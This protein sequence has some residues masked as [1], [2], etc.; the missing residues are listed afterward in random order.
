M[1]YLKSNALEARSL[2]SGNAHR[3]TAS[4]APSE[5]NEVNE[6]MPNRLGCELGAQMDDLQRV[7]G[8]ASVVERERETLRGEGSLRR[9]FEDD[10]IAGDECREHGVDHDE[11]RVAKMYEKERVR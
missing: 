8:D 6:A 5:C 2:G 4:D 7:L 3:A 1:T 10:D 9:W 11:V